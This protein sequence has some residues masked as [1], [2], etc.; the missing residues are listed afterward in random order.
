M[1]IVLIGNFAPPYE[2]ENLHNLSF[3]RKL[4]DDGHE[5]SVINTSLNP[6]GDKKFVNT[7]SYIDFVIKLLRICWGKDIVH[8]S[9]KGYL[10]LGL[11]K[12]MTSILIGKFFRA[13][14]FITIHSEL[15]SIQG[16]MRSPVGGRQT[17]FT[18][19]TFADKIICADKDTYH[20]ASLYMRKSNFELIPTFVYIPGDIS[21]QETPLLSKLKNK[22]KVIIFSNVKY[23]SF[24]F[25]ILREMISDNAL[26]PNIALVISLSEKPSG[27]FQ[28]VLEETGKDLADNLVFIEP[29]DLQT[30]LRAYAKAD[31]IIRPLSCDG[32]TFFEGFS[33]SVKKL[34]RSGDY[35]YT[36]SGL[37]FVK[38]GETAGMCVC[39]INT[40]LCMEKETISDLKIEE[41]YKRI[42]NLYEK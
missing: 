13:K 36:P 3:L 31:I 8:F 6:A 12:L 11:L 2:E 15:F 22:E 4:E 38:E 27:K 35:V 9:T 17:L 19:F 18:S 33:I 24:L 5:C 16:Q 25:D 10:R 30:T 26:P 39:I 40:M 34:L 42:K 20:V 32:I 29:D 21:T 28:H 1:K 37:I 23:P 14:T 41:S 7:G